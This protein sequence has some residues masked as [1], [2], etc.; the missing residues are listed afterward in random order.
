MSRLLNI[1]AIRNGGIAGRYGGEEFVIAFLGKTVKEVYEIARQAHAQIG[2]TP[3][4]FA[5]RVLQIT[6]S[7][8]VAGYPETCENPMD[9]LTRADWAMYT[10][11]QNGRNRITID[12]DKVRNEM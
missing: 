3:I 4:H 2:A 1:A 12:S 9:L 7:A 8:G 5:D 11:K 6:A 10:S